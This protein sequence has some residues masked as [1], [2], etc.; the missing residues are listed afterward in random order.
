MQ[1]FG[2]LVVVVIIL[3]LATLYEF[4]TKGTVSNLATLALIGAIGLKYAV[5]TCVDEPTYGGEEQQDCAKN[6]SDALEENINLLKDTENAEENAKMAQSQLSKANVLAQENATRDAAQRADDAR[7][8]SSQQTQLDTQTNVIT[9]L[10]GE[11]N[12][13]ELTNAKLESDQRILAAKINNQKENLE[14]ALESKVDVE[15]ELADCNK[16]NLTC[17]NNL[18]HI[19]DE[20]KNLEEKLNAC[21]ESLKKIKRPRRG[22]LS[23]W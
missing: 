2:L 20:K 8:I 13:L 18:T 19:T 12:K 5:P 7:R 16:E 9:T 4:V 1:L 22:A 6:L 10:R 14:A 17:V 15:T 3:L 23:F 21:N 11:K